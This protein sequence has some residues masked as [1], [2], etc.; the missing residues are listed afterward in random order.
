M[1]IKEI[2]KAVADVSKAQ[3]SLE[4]VYGK[5][6][7][8]SLLALAQN[9]LK[10]TKLYLESTKV[11]EGMSDEEIESQKAEE[12]RLEQEQLQEEMKQRL[13]AMRPTTVQEEV[14]AQ[15]ET[16]PAPEATAP[17]GD[18]PT[19]ENQTPPEAPATQA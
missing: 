10:Q 5:E 15:D 1:N 8:V 6:F 7:A 9:Q 4:S 2:E 11:Y 12:K 13:E 14:P 16:P 17:E 19:G 3:K 18:S